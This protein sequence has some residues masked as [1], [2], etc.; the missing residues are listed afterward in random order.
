MDEDEEDQ[1]EGQI[2]I[3]VGMTP[4]FLINFI[5][6]TA[7]LILWRISR[8]TFLKLDETPGSSTTWTVQ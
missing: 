1:A 5:Q 7:C 3:V 4:W 6:K 8:G 2:W